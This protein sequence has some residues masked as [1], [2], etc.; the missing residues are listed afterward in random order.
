[1]APVESKIGGRRAGL[2]SVQK[3]TFGG[4]PSSPVAVPTEL[5]RLTAVGTFNVPNQNQVK[6]SCTP[7]LTY[8]LIVSFV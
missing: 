5:H 2:D 7:A 8:F 1:M 3:R 4:Q 6:L